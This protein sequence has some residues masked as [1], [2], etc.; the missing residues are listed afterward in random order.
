VNDSRSEHP[1]EEAKPMLLFTRKYLALAAALLAAGLSTGCSQKN[2]SEAGGD[3]PGAKAKVTISAA[4]VAQTDIARIK[5]T[6]TGTATDPMSPMTTFLT[7]SGNVW[8]GNL[9]HIPAA[10]AGSIRTFLAEAMS[11]SN[12]VIYRG[13]TT[14]TVT[15]GNTA[16][17]TI[18]LQQTDPSPGLTNSAPVLDSVTSTNAYVLPGQTLTFGVVAHD[19]DHLTSPTNAAF[20]GQPFA[21]TW[22][23]QCTGGAGNGAFSGQADTGT[24][25]TVTFAPPAITSTTCSIAIKVK[26]G[27]TVAAADQLAVTTYFNIVVN[28]NFTD[29]T[30]F[31]FPN[32]APIV[33]ASGDLRWN[34]FA[35]VLDAGGNPIPVGIQGDFSF[36]VTDTDGDNV[37]YDVKAECG[38]D[39]A[40][41]LTLL[42]AGFWSPA[43]TKNDVASSSFAPTLGHGGA[44]SP[45]TDPNQDCRITLDVHDLCTNGNCTGA[46]GATGNLADGS[47][48][49]YNWGGTTYTSVTTIVIN[50]KRPAVPAKAPQI[51]YATNGATGSMPLV[52]PVTAS[53]DPA[54]V[55]LV[56]ANAAGYAMT[57][58]ATDPQATVANPPTVTWGCFY[59]AAG[60]PVALGGTIAQDPLTVDATGQ[61]VHQDV[62]WSTPAVLFQGMYCTATVASTVAPFLSTVVTYH[63]LPNDPCAKN[64]WAE[65]TICNDQNA[66]NGDGAANG[67][68]TATCDQN[69]VC[70]GSSIGAAWAAA[71]PGKD[72]TGTA[73]TCNSANAC[74]VDSCDKNVGCVKTPQPTTFLCTGDGN[75]C[76]HND[77]CD[78][79]TAG[80]CVT[81]AP[82]VCPAVSVNQCEQSG[83]G[84]CASTGNNSY[85]CNYAPK[86]T[87]TVCDLDGNGCTV[88]TCQPS[89]ATAACTAPAAPVSCAQTGV[90][91]QADAGSCVS[92]SSTASHCAFPNLG[93]GSGCNNAGTCVVGQTCLAG[94]CQG[95]TSAC[96]AGQS[97]TPTATPT[98]TPTAVHPIVAKDVWVVPPAGIA[99]DTTGNT[100][101]AATYALNTVTDFGG[102][103]AF[104]A[105][106][107]NDAWVAKYDGAGAT[108][109]AVDIG[110]DDGASANDQSATGVAVT[111]DGNVAIIG[112]I[113][114]QATFGTDVVISAGGV[115][116][117]AS[118]ASAD[119][120]RR[121]AK[122]YD[123]GANAGFLAVATN[124][125]HASQ[126]IAVCGVATK[127]ATA[128][129]TGAV[130]G[131]S[132]D[133]VIA[134]FDPN[135]AN[136]LVWSAQI[137][138]TGGET[139]QALAIDDNGDVFAAGQL[140]VSN[141]TFP[142]TTPVTLTGTGTTA[143]KVGWVAKFAGGG[144]GAGGANTLAA[145]GYATT[146]NAQVRPTALAVVGTDVVMG[147]AFGLTAQFG[148]YAITSNGGDDAFLVRLSG[149]GAS[150]SLQPVWA[151]ASF[152]GSGTETLRGLAVTSYGDIV[153]T[154]TLAPSSTAFK[155][156]HAGLDIV[157]AFSLNVNGT[158]A[159]DMY[160][161]K[162]D[163]STGANQNAQKY[164][165]ATTQNGDAVAVNRFGTNQVALAGTLNGSATFGSAAVTAAN[166]TDVVLVFGDLQ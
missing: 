36:A 136:K 92:D 46:V 154:G 108:Q 62:S 83:T 43:A 158:T 4:A 123:L 144:N 55:M 24:T 32:T 49:T 33:T 119:G 131:G 115:P 37:R 90:A 157:G 153:A 35:S 151:P 76:T 16:M 145:V 116:Y 77:H 13:Q 11:S 34:Y 45:I 75:G 156:A 57:V 40:G 79:T 5:L 8:T 82:V 17:V 164:G 18:F 80:A 110:D 12:S 74:I 31:A 98:C 117:V 139:C 28:G 30:V 112:K 25:S 22:S 23:A 44:A 14:A 97:C 127:A 72:H 3:S 52:S 121:W 125:N 67:P 99:M 87:G 111:K 162:F 65:G 96:P 61:T 73:I 102:G 85:A 47:D 64:G 122:A 146:S 69:K 160:V 59:D 113:A 53:W 142:G 150:P 21:F 155:T 137:G 105:V 86:A 159:P 42:G 100:F 29:A 84:V 129:V 41:A 152:G 27:N 165:D 94:A 81:G 148:T 104:K 63:F 138:G 132:S 89:G 19:P 101:A 128:L 161:A 130:Y 149:A 58:D 68:E 10:A 71:N 126:R 1:I 143:K 26:E 106:G 163:G 88:D 56:D 7:K 91:C 166:G 78:G 6:V 95:G 39:L 134:V 70:A 20:D 93:D 140:D 114:G 118:L 2:A 50:G 141:V 54:R 60:T 48:K 107:G 109:W 9:T 133:V 120:A 124:P 66:C 103:F 38:P 15:A 147:G 51:N 135:A